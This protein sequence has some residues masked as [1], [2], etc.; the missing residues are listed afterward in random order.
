M[1]LSNEQLLAFAFAKLISQRKETLKMAALAL[2]RLAARL[3][4][5]NC[6]A[7]VAQIKKFK[8]YE[9]VFNFINTI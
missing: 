2:S 1:V 4:E 8:E 9:Q 6:G 3:D 7:F 5:Y